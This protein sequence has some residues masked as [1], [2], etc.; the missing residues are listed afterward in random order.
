MADADDASAPVAGPAA[1][2]AASRHDLR[3]IK[4]VLAPGA[5]PVLAATGRGWSPR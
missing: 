5:D 2:S 4:I 3:A 1:A